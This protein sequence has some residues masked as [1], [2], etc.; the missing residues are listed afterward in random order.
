MTFAMNIGPSMFK[1]QQPVALLIRMSCVVWV[2]ALGM[3]GWF[4]VSRFGRASHEVTYNAVSHRVSDKVERFLFMLSPPN[5]TQMFSVLVVRIE[6]EVPDE[7][8]VDA[9]L[10]LLWYRAPRQLTIPMQATARSGTNRLFATGLFSYDAIMSQVSVSGNVRNIRQ[11]VIKYVLGDAEFA[12]EVFVIRFVCMCVSAVCAFAYVV[13]N[14]IVWKCRAKLAVAL[15]SIC[16]VLSVVANCPMIYSYRFNRY[17]VVHCI[18]SVARGVFGAFNIIALFLFVY[19]LNGG[20]SPEFV[21]LMSILFL[22]G[23]AVGF[24]VTDTRILALFFDANIDVWMF[25]MSISVTGRIVLFALLLYETA[26]TMHLARSVDKP[27]VYSYALCAV[28]LIGTNIGQAFWYFSHSYGNYA[29]DFF[30]DYLLQTLISLIYADL[31]W[32][33]PPPLRKMSFI[34]HHFQSTPLGFPDIGDE[35]DG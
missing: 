14:V 8:Y 1:F 6:T 16:L 10:T 15:T 13:D 19:N 30:G 32:I 20:K 23:H 27:L 9:D 33:H 31:H 11:V 7:F 4:T 25:F 18:D 29:L 26:A 28:C 24:L 5:Y 35:T 17:F 2:V 34:E 21:L 3:A 22:L 12:R